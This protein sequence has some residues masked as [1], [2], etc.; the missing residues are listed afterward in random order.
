MY[1]DKISLRMD[2][3]VKYWKEK[4]LLLNSIKNNYAITE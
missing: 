2:G 1:K 4:L 3:M